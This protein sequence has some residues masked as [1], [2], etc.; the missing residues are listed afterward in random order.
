MNKKKIITCLVFFLILG[1]FVAIWYVSDPAVYWKEMVQ[2][3][4]PE[5]GYNTAKVSGEWIPFMVRWS[6]KRFFGMVFRPSAQ[7]IIGFPTQDM[8]YVFYE[9][10]KRSMVVT[11]HVFDNLV[12]GVTIIYNP[13]MQNE[14]QTIKKNILTLHPQMPVLMKEDAVQSGISSLDLVGVDEKYRDVVRNQKVPVQ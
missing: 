11:F 8:N 5:T 1:G 6:P 2:Y 13:K 4:K 3:I 12:R 14:A 9:N 10:D 7:I